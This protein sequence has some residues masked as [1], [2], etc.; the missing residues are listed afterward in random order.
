MPSL[1]FAVFPPPDL[2]VK[3]AADAEALQ[4]AGATLIPAERLHVTLAYLGSRGDDDQCIAA[5]RG[6]LDRVDGLPADTEFGVVRTFGDAGARPVVLTGLHDNP[7]VAEL[8]AL[9]L[10]E[11]ER[12]RVAVDTAHDYLPHV[13]IAYADIHIE[14]TRVGPY[15]PRFG[16]IALVRGGDYAVLARRPL[17]VPEGFDGAFISWYRDPTPSGRPLTADEYRELGASAHRD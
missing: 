5:A 7:Y 1:F 12:V 3:I 11:L 8:R 13:T 15:C 9:L 6:A 14:P 10:P 16:E 4:L 2:A 17:P